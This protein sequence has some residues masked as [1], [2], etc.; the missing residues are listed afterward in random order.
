MRHHIFLSYSRKDTA[1]MQQLRH[2]LNM[3]GLSIWTDEGIEPGTSSWK[4]AIESA[5][6]D[7]GCLV[8]I[9]SPDA[10]QSQWVRAELDFAELQGIS[11]FPILARGEERT[12]I[13]FGF[14]ASQNEPLF[15]SGLQHL[16]G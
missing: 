8:A 9:L 13:P 5:I 14:A 7:A 3:A 4:R 2:D 6:L 12:S 11:I 10:S 15:P 1:V 16:S